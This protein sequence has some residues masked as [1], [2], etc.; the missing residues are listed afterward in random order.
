MEI[1]KSLINILNWINKI[2][3]DKE[4][5]WE[6]DWWCLGML[7]YEMVVGIPAFYHED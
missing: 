5:T 4:Y 2:Y 6:S 7:L 3:K 1:L